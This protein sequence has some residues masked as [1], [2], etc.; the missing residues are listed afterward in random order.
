MTAITAKMAQAALIDMVSESKDDILKPYLTSLKE[1]AI[2]QLGDNRVRIGPFDC[3]VEESR[4]YAY[5]RT[6]GIL[7]EYK[8]VFRFNRDGIWTAS[9]AGRSRDDIDK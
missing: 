3:Y 9:I 2:V 5:F 1:D 4:S 7:W 6:P 8:G